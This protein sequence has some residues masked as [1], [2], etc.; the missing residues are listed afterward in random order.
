MRGRT[1]GPPTLRPGE[2]FAQSLVAGFSTPAACDASES[3]KRQQ[4]LHALDT[5]HDVDWV[6]DVREVTR[7]LHALVSRKRDVLAWDLLSALQ[8]SA[9]QVDRFHYNCVIGGGAQT[10]RWTSSLHVLT[11]ILA[12]SL[13]PDI[14]SYSAAIGACKEAMQ[15]R[16]ALGLL[17]TAGDLQGKL[18]AVAFGSATSSCERTTAWLQAIALSRCVAK[19]VG[20]ASTAACN[21]ALS[22]CSSVAYWDTA[23]CL[24]GDM[25]SMR[26]C[27]DEVTYGSLASSMKESGKWMLTSGLLRCIRQ[28]RVQLNPVIGSA[29]VASCLGAGKDKAWKFSLH[30]AHQVVQLADAR[31]VPVSN[32]FIHV[33]GRALRWRQSQEVIRVMKEV[34]VEPGIVTYSASLQGLEEEANWPRC[35]EILSSLPKA[36]VQGN[37]VTEGQALKAQVSSAAWSRC[38]LA[39]R[40]KLRTP[41][42]VNED[43]GIILSALAAK[44]CWH[45]AVHELNMAAASDTVVRRAMLGLL[46]KTSQWQGAVQL[47]LQETSATS[48]ERSP[49]SQDAA[50]R[51]AVDACAQ[52]GQLD[53]GRKLL[54]AVQKDPL[55][56]VLPETGIWCLA[57]LRCMDAELIDESLQ[58]LRQSCLTRKSTPGDI[59]ALAWSFSELLVEDA[60]LWR[61]IVDAAMDATSSF[62]IRDLSRLVWALVTRRYDVSS[63]GKVLW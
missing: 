41:W 26:A 36:G 1:T 2:E 38:L 52:A 60:G 44:S 48:E 11:R 51:L 35:M 14:V 3:A 43:T 16:T 61:S 19:E 20:A 7:C 50:V 37:E 40:R 23:L 9:C 25:V 54:E 46:A 29:L 5:W 30:M 28:Q 15:W 57:Q 4:I 17:Q 56:T 21:A 45:Q 59:S 39:L 6:E 53:M 49:G 24:F 27:T 63:S 31:A 55:I 33:L 42:V 18:D 62:G 22:A 58:R 13:E 47:F 8:S 32:A 10:G 34:Q 12:G